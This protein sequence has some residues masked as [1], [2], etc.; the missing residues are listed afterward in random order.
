MES[1]SFAPEGQNFS[2]G[3]YTIK[4]TN[5][6][7]GSLQFPSTEN[8]QPNQEVTTPSGETVAPPKNINA[9][10]LPTEPFEYVLPGGQRA[11]AMYSDP[12]Y[13][14]GTLDYTARTQSK[15]YREVNRWIFDAAEHWMNPV[16]IGDGV[17]TYDERTKQSL[18]I[19]A[20]TTNPRDFNKFI[21]NIQSTLPQGKNTPTDAAWYIVNVEKPRTDHDARYVF[22]K[23]RPIIKEMIDSGQKKGYFS[24]TSLTERDIVDL[25]QK[26]GVDPHIINRLK[27]EA[28][29]KDVRQKTNTYTMSKLRFMIDMLDPR[30]KQGEMVLANPEILEELEGL[31][32]RDAFLSM[33]DYKD[34]H[35]GNFVGG[36][37]DGISHLVVETGY[38][39]GGLAE[40]TYGSLVAAGT[41]GNVLVKNDRFVLSDR[42]MMKPQ[43]ERDEANRI[44]LKAHEYATKI[45]P[46]LVALS[47]QEGKQARYIV[48]RFGDSADPEMIATFRK[49][50]ELKDSG[51][52]REQFS[53]ERLANFGEG[54]LQS[55]PNL[56]KFFTDSTDPGSVL[57]RAESNIKRSPLALLSNATSHTAL[58][59][60]AQYA[61]VA[62]TAIA[63]PYQAWIQGTDHYKELT[64][65]QLDKEIDQYLDNWRSTAMKTDPIVAQMYSKLGMNEAARAARGQLQEERLQQ[66][67]AVADP[68]TLTI[69]AMKLLGVG[70]KAAQAAATI[71]K[72]SKGFKA[73]SAEANAARVAAGGAKDVAF[74]TAID[75]VR[76]LLKRTTR[77]GAEITDDDVIAIALTDPRKTGT[78]GQTAAA[79]LIRKRIGKT[80][81]KNEN[82][83]TRASQLQAELDA[84]P[85]AA[86]GTT[87]AK[88]DAM[89]ARLIAGPLQKGAGVGINFAGRSLQGLGDFFESARKGGVVEGNLVKRGIHYFAG[90]ALRQ[91]GFSALAAGTTAAAVSGTTLAMLV[92][93][94][95]L[96][97]ALAGAGGAGV[98]GAA[99]SRFT[100]SVLIRPEVLEAVGTSVAGFGRIQ[101]A[102]GRNTTGGSRYGGSI[103]VQ[104]AMDLEAEAARF[105]AIADSTPAAKIRMKE[106]VDD[107]VWLRRAHKSGL[108]DVMRN[109]A[110]V[111]WEDGFIS[112]GTGAFLAHLNDR[113]ATGAGAGVGIGF[114][115][116]L[117]AAGRLYAMVPSGAQ[118][119]LDK[120]VLGDL[121][122]LLESPTDRGGIDPASRARVFEYLDGADK[123]HP[124]DPTKASAEYIKRANIVRDLVITHKGQMSFVNT[125]EFETAQILTNDPHI[126]ATQILREA[127]EAFPGEGEGAKREAFIK[128]RTE[129]LAKA[130]QA[131]DSVTVLQNDINAQ[132][133]KLAARNDALAKGKEEIA[134]LEAEV[135]T[136]EG[137][138]TTAQ[139]D[140]MAK[141][142]D[143]IVALKKQADALDPQK[144]TAE[145][146]K[147][148]KQMAKLAEQAQGQ[149][150]GKPDPKAVEAA[151]VKLERALENQ[152]R[153]EAESQLITREVEQL[154]GKLA[155]ARIDA[156]NPVPMRP[157]ETR[158]DANGNTT[159]KIANGFYIVDGPQGR[160]TYIDINKID[161]L[162]AMSEGWHALLQD[163]AV[164]DAMPDMVRMMWGQEGDM[165]GAGRTVAY[166]P[167]VS[168]ALVTAYAA[169]LPP[170]Q[171]ARYMAEFKAAKDAYV[172]SGGKDFSA[173][174][175]PTQEILTWLMATIDGNKRTAYRPGVSTAEGAAASSAY[176]KGEAGKPG[177]S[178]GW[179]DIRKILFGDRKVTDEVSRAAR[180]MFDPNTG[181]F[182]RRSASHMKAQLEAAG[183]RFIEAGDGTLRGYFFNNKNEIIRN[184]V[185]NEFY[186]RVIALTGGS[187]SRRVKPVSL[188]DPLV[189]VQQRVDFAKSN[190]FDWMLTPDGTNI[191]T[192]E[193]IGQ[194]SDAFTRS[195]LSDLANVPD[196]S[197]GMIRYT[198]PKNPKNFT[199]TGIP[200]DAEIAAIANNTTLPAA[201]KENLLTVMKAMAAGESPTVLSFDYNNIFS[202]NKDAITE[203][204]LRIPQDIAGKTAT[205]RASPMSISI[206]EVVVYNEKGN[207]V[208]VPD[209]E[210]PGKQMDQKQ[211]VVK[212]KMFG[213][214]EFIRS[215]NSAFSEG[216]WYKD[217]DGK[218]V[219]MVK[220][221][222]G[223]DYTP[224][225][226]MSLF[227]DMAGFHEKATIMMNYHYGKGPIDPYSATPSRL[228]EPSADVLDPKNPEKGAAMRDAIRVIFGTESGQK[229]LPFV[230]GNTQTNAATGFAVRGTDYSVTDFRLDQMGFAVATAQKMFLTQRGWTSSQFVFSLNDWGRVNVP[231]VKGVSQMIISATTFEGGKRGKVEGFNV[232]TELTHPILP[233]VRLYVGNV[234]G[235]RSYAY[236]MGDGNIRHISAKNQAE[237]LEVVRT[238][239]GSEVESQLWINQALADF[240]EQN[241]AARPTVTLPPT[242]PV[243][244]KGVRGQ[245]QPITLTTIRDTST[246][247]QAGAKY[248]YSFANR[249]KPDAPYLSDGRMVILKA[250][251]VLVEGWR[252]M[253][254]KVFGTKRESDPARVINDEGVG[255]TLVSTAK[256][257]KEYVLMTPNFR[258]DTAIESINYSKTYSKTNYKDTAFTRLTS[259]EGTGAVFESGS[260]EKFVALLDENKVDLYIKNPSKD[261][262]RSRLVAVVKG[263]KIK[264]DGSNIVGVLEGHYGSTPAGFKKL[265]KLQPE[266]PVTMTKAELQRASVPFKEL[267]TDRHGWGDDALIVSKGYDPKTDTHFTLT[268]FGENYQAHGM[269]KVGPN[270][271]LK[272]VIKLFS[273]GINPEKPFY[274]APYRLSLDA[275]A[276]D[277]AG[278]GAG[279]G[280][281]GGEA[282][283]DGP[284]VLIS[285]SGDRGQQINNIRDIAYV[286]V[287]DGAYLDPDAAVAILRDRLPKGVEVIKMSEESKFLVKHKEPGSFESKPILPERTPDQ[288]AP[289]FMYDEAMPPGPTP[290]ERAAWNKDRDEILAEQRGEDPAV[291]EEER[292]RIQG[293]RILARLEQRRQD[294]KN[295]EAARQRE[296]LK[297]QG[298]DI[299]DQAASDAGWEQYAQGHDKRQ[300]K[301][302]RDE[303]RRLGKIEKAL[304]DAE[305]DIARQEAARAEE[306]RKFYDAQ[307]KADAKAAREAQIA[308]EK[309]DAI[310][311]ARQ[312]AL[313]EASQRVLEGRT[314]SAAARAAGMQKLVDE[315]FAS[316][317]PAISPG[318]LR[319]SMD[320][321]GPRLTRLAYDPGTGIAYSPYTGAQMDTTLPT[322]PGVFQKPILTS[323]FSMTESSFPA[324][325]P[326]NATPEQTKAWLEQADV[327]KRVTTAEANSAFNQQYANRG[328]GNEIAGRAYAGPMK[329]QGVLNA[330]ERRIW[331]TEGGIRLVR[332]YNKANE[333]GFGSTVFYKVY[334][335]NGV[336]IY[337]GNNSV[338]AL[339]AAQKLKAA[340]PLAKDLG[341]Y[342]MPTNEKARKAELATRAGEA[343][344]AIET[345]PA[346]DKSRTGVNTQEL[347]QKGAVNR[348]NR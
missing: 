156:D 143:E 83:A 164:Q 45:G 242:V 265:G 217:K 166:S 62:Y 290:Q 225:Y 259:P 187:Q 230:Q 294:A 34:R 31:A 94:D 301:Q 125:A 139:A 197:R 341:V 2:A 244:P 52:Y 106:L 16:K 142:Q 174:V 41:L 287:N 343:A 221:P 331:E 189:P 100:T 155:K 3:D 147:L 130:R 213:S 257:R 33:A 253:Q 154:N 190:G 88:I 21:S 170:D 47:G 309:I 85:D 261:S 71:D 46:E 281:S 82:F 60:L 128:A 14:V 296:L 149:N 307:R 24:P 132:Q 231:Q 1:P 271:A 37:L 78:V 263:Q 226:L 315:F 151:N 81:A 193:A 322:K 201:I 121:A 283:K 338:D 235:E 19:A 314:E 58:G 186:D 284:L 306:I 268:A 207:P 308:A 98:L 323:R 40:G 317:E 76:E 336:M 194:K 169:D 39:V 245:R 188:Y 325:L 55:V 43:A 247:A 22:G 12:Q 299:R 176:S 339:E 69:G 184:P 302:A 80:I 320:E 198:D 229:R 57:F 105:A 316:N 239:I 92:E 348:Y 347:K 203:R 84:I 109:T 250:D 337:N 73:L 293:Q 211:M 97:A 10:G 238:A 104:T 126:E 346:N 227:G 145:I 175:A 313:A 275:S 177:D 303:A 240:T 167:E 96:A 214:D 332:E 136:L 111:V 209:P 15:G 107:A 181:M 68:I 123:L 210:N 262:S 292:K 122:T 152:S 87:K 310:I 114:S 112:G 64:G 180:M 162:G 324:N 255:M 9:D 66:A 90:I 53:A 282:V 216:L 267:D 172:A 28:V 340:H 276:T 150:F 118:P 289:L 199:I 279:L 42:W 117:R 297:E 141:I 17:R 192:P 129:R 102:L 330:V 212:V 160:R 195:I 305:Q 79:A 134:K 72:V 218:K 329:G 113:D 110:R 319:I 6:G 23:V 119:I 185:L 103:F 11:G 248:K 59:P 266:K 298:G 54:I 89:R 35:G 27:A 234:K 285:R 236:T 50:S 274:T 18:S 77:Y 138:Q 124:N 334:G 70:A 91:P 228:S 288:P 86:T 205:R 95:V 269:S 222:Q 291:I 328:R 278:A 342:N 44:L 241:A 75:Q 256:G 63:S 161:N 345:P 178:I 127:M 220:D 120:T 65:A 215:T 344:Q 204:R 202:V 133:Q 182:V 48:S 131:T 333:K 273:E 312:R 311:T 171:K 304:L 168:E 224:E 179:S 30:A 32:R 258:V 321:F 148:E 13:Q 36:L 56:V 163:A 158:I 159:R 183:M 173:L 93:G 264:A 165:S 200:T 206:E 99:G 243:E 246:Q 7:E 5:F 20:S 108:E 116:G 233:D 8:V 157:Y 144:D 249:A 101:R 67:A 223:N 277:R 272:N 115:T 153:L 61:N 146:I 280:T 137:A 270:T 4:P 208:R 26:S 74:Q 140:A 327:W 135:A 191:L 25:A 335:A 219:G 260:L 252:D 318:L 286:M 295:L 300:Q 196:A 29:E 232:E 237:A 51:A 251:E 38:A 49:L 254:D 326:K